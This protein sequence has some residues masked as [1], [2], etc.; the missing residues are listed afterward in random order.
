VGRETADAALPRD[1][2]GRKVVILG[3]GPAGLMAAQTL[4]RRGFEVE[5]LEQ[6]EEPGGQ[7]NT[8]A[9]CHLKGK[10]HWCIEDLME[11]LRLLGVPVRTG[12][13]ATAEEILAKRPYAVFFATG[14]RPLVPKLLPGVDRPQVC[15]APDIIH[16]R[17]NI[18]N[19]RVVV[20]GSGMTGLET[21]ELLSQ[22]GND[23]TVVEMAKE[24]A[25][26]TW[27]QLKDDEMERLLPAG[28]RFSPGS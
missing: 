3:A 13:T 28:V 20:V 21:A 8:A 24:I 2:Y 12:V 23:V 15:T 18:E 17:R 5:V 14:A 27:F 4:A 9:A 26:G 7:V 22:A 25:P 6:K 1:G 16:G 11:S 19:K 10:L